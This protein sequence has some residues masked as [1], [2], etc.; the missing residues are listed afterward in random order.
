[1]SL[2]LNNPPKILYLS[3]NQEYSCL[4]CGTDQG[5]VIYNINPPRVRYHRKFG[6]G[7]GIVEVLNKSNILVLVGGGDHPKYPVNKLVIWD[8]YNEQILTDVQ[9]H[10]K[11]LGVK[12]TKDCLAIVCKSVVKLYKLENLKFLYK[13]ETYDNPNGLCSLSSAESNPIVVVPGTEQGSVTIL[14]YQT[15][16]KKTINDCHKNPIKS[17]ALNMN[18]TKFATSSES[19]TMIH[20]YD[21]ETNAKTNEFRRGSG[22]CDMYSINFS[23]DSTALVATSDKNTVHVFSLLKDIKNRRS[24]M[25]AIGG[26]VN[27]LKSEWSLFEVDWEPLESADKDEKT[28]ILEMKRR[29]I[30]AI[31]DPQ[32][33]GM[34][35]LFTV[36]Y[37]GKF[38]THTFRLLSPN[39]HHQSAQS[40]GRT[41]GDEKS[42][43]DNGKDEIEKLSSGNLFQLFN[44]TETLP[45]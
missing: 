15:G 19:G 24:K 30:S 27:F 34:H 2:D 14:N 4:N 45:Q 16:V 5:F 25:R 28:D 44:E 32:D 35:T 12:L 9:T 40:G 20:V 37:D 36:G 18:A 43:K 6:A 39:V 29:H 23:K 42:S 33:D 7:I 22:S 8:D 11:I 1:M 10:Y 17:I 26:M 21:I 31:I 38:T 3:F 13:I 41:Q